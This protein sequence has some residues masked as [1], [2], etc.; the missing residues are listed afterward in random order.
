MSREIITNIPD[1]QYLLSLLEDN[2]G[3]IFIKFGAEWCGPC[4]KIEQYV[5]DK[6]NSFESHIQSA[7]I[8]IDENLDV[9]AFLKRK[10][11]ATTIPSIVCYFKGTDSYVPDDVICD[12]NIDNIE[13]F[14]NNC[15]ETYNEL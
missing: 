3:I 2:P 13:N 1:R 10:K 14:F 5:H 9:Y 12:S 7:I 11:I 8:D 4:K 6:F 15:F